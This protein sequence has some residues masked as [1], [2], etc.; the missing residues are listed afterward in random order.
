MHHQ[1]TD[2]VFSYVLRCMII[3]CTIATILLFIILFISIGLLSIKRDV[4]IFM[5]STFVIVQN[6]FNIF[7]LNIHFY[8]LY[9][10]HLPVLIK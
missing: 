6:K 3:L 4:N 2:V 10:L 9:R 1:I 7:F 5:V 8:I